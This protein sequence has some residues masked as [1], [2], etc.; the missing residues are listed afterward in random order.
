MEPLWVR[1]NRDKTRIIHILKGEAFRFLDFD[2]HREPK[3]RGSGHFILTTP[4][5]KA[6]KAVKAK[7][8][9]II[10]NSGATPAKEIMSKINCVLTGWLNYFF[11][12]LFMQR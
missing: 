2:F 4:Q 8:H 9:D 3:N 5:K 6:R 1:L 11:A 12:I 10:C 7:I